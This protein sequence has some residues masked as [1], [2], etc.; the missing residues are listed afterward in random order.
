MTSTNTESSPLSARDG[1]NSQGAFSTFHGYA[2]VHWWVGNAK[3]AASYYV[4]R[5]GFKRLA[6]K[7]LETG[8]RVVASHVVTNGRVT[9]VLSSPLI[10][11]SHAFLT[12]H[13]KALLNEMHQ[14][15]ERHGDAV[16][17]ENGVGSTQARPDNTFTI[18]ADC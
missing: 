13:D 8:S 2:Y 16:K 12:E 7:G 1:Q 14:H 6:Y 11:Q 3:Q 10:M 5:M 17:G 4:T 9:F 15:Q 18:P